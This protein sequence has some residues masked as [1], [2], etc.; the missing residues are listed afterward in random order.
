[1][2]NYKIKSYTTQLHG[3]HQLN[4]TREGNHWTQ[5]GNRKQILHGDL[6]MPQFIEWQIQNPQKSTHPLLRQPLSCKIITISWFTNV[7]GISFSF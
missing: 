4:R 3:V 6:T 5:G 1:M 2:V 7:F